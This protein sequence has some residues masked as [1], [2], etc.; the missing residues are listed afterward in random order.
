MVPT[1]RPVALIVLDGWGY[2]ENRE[3]NAIAHAHTPNWDKL[4]NTYPHTLIYASEKAVGLPADQMGNSEVGHL[5]LGAGRIV[6]QET[7]RVINAIESGEFFHNPV[8]CS[9]LQQAVKSGKS[10]HIIGLLSDGGV[11]SHIQHIQAMVRMAAQ[12]GADSIYLHAFTDGRDTAPISALGY[13]EQMEQTFAEVGK[14]QFASIIGRYFSMDRDNRWA[15]VQAAFELIANGKAHFTAHSAADAVN[16]GYERD[17]TDEFIKSTAI[18]D[19]HD[20][21]VRMQDGDLAIFM[22]FRS[23]RARQL[24][25]AFIED[26]FQSFEQSHRPK[27]A[28]FVT[29]TQYSADFNAPI[30]FTPSSLENVFG[31]YI[32]NLGLKQLRIA[33]TE[34]YAHVTFFLNG[35]V[36]EPFP[37]EDRILVPSPKVATYD[38][39]PEMNAAEVTDRLINAIDSH[40]YDAI[41]C[42]FA[43]PD[44]VG[45]TGNFD[46]TVRA[47]EALDVCIGRV[48]DALTAAGGEALITADHG[49]AEMMLNGETG[50]AHT[51][52]TMN[53]VPFLY[54]GRAAT[55]ADTG[56]LSDVTPTMLYLMGLDKPKEMT[57]VSLVTLQ[58]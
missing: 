54:I 37:G 17:E 6:Y 32:S 21:P 22:N 36:E 50:Q 51:A 43:N 12:Q 28:N 3:N 1:T 52:H 24:T 30:A 2:S 58:E 9:N 11:H 18:L 16:A 13:I 44:M 35:G 42:N 29:L 4:W 15:R 7:S 48:I 39:Q 56:A 33:E 57:G 27:L 38:L 47:I 49:N 40:Q 19:A 10:V 41:I 53:P 34:K 26:D 25:R 20:Q 14:G 23:D 46:A 5:N 8:L 55:M 45:H 31:E